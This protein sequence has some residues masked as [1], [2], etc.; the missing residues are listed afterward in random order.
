MLDG[1][2]VLGI[3]PARA[4]SKRVLNKNVRDLNGK[5]LIVWTL[6]DLHK[7]KYIDHAYVST[8]S[9]EIQ[10][11][12]QDLGV[13]SDPLRPKDLA[14]DSSSSFD[15]VLDVV[16]NKK[17]GYDIII[18]LQP[19]SPFRRIEDIDSSLEYYLQK[20]ALSVTSVCSTET[21]STWCSALPDDKSMNDMVKG[22][23][24]K[25]SQDL[26]VEYKING[27][28][29]IIS[30]EAFKNSK[31]FFADTD[32]YAYVMSRKDSIDIDTE[33]DLLFAECL[34]RMEV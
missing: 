34:M 8:D 6:Q 20:N 1:R 14:T 10:K 23:E 25:R 31:S 15:V 27:A 13:D 2:K 21:H 22:I 12:A 16:T 24:S 19:T 32:A 29:Y 33:E 18:L 30:I 3:I 7:S 9:S 17:P 4:G 5:P 28:I 26:E 11:I